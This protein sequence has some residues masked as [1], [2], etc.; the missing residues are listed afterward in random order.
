MRGVVTSDMSL[1]SIK[2]IVASVS[3]GKTGKAFMLGTEGEYI[4]FIDA[5]RDVDD[6]IQSDS[7]KNLAALGRTMLASTHG[8]ADLELNGKDCRVYY[9]TIA[10]SNWKIAVL[11]DNT[12]I[13]SS[14]RGSFLIMSIMPLLGLILVMISISFAAGHLRKVVGKVNRFSDIA[15]SGD[16]SRRIEV[17]EHDEFGIMET[18]LN[19]MMDNMAGMYARSLKLKEEA[20]NA[21]MAKSSFLSNMSH[22]MRTPLNAIIGMTAIG[23]LAKDIEKKDYAF[24]KVADASAHLLGVINDILD[25]SK[26]EANK[27]ELSPIE[28]DL[29]RMLQRVINV[30]NFRVDE[31]QQKLTVRIDK[32]IPRNLIGDDQRLSQVIANLLSNA[33]KFTPEGGSVHLDVRLFERTGDVCVLQFKVTDTGIGLSSDQQ[34]RLFMPFQQADNNTSRK[35]GGTGLGLT[36]SKRIVEMMGGEISIESV[37]GGGAIFSFTARLERGTN[38]PQSLLPSGIDWKNV[39]ILAV[40]DAPDIREYFSEIANI[41]GVSCDVAASGSEAKRLIDEKGSYDIYFVDWKMPGM[42][43]LELSAI[44]KAKDQEKSVII[45]I[46]SIEWGVIE[47]EAKAAGVKK[48]LPKPLFPSSVA[49]CISECLGIN[50]LRVSE[51]TQLDDMDGLEGFRVLIVEDVEINREIVL[52][53]LEPTRLEIDCAENG[54]EAVR[55]FSNAPDKYDI[56]FMDIQ[57]PEMDGYEATRRIRM[58]NQTVPIVAMTANVFREDVERCIASGMNDHVGKPLDVSEVIAKLRKYLTQK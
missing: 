45:M 35:Y 31:K 39:R 3:V 1:D 4:S 21:N 41:L 9:D 27:L 6:K 16:F 52:S 11:V 7:D 17:T 32:N 14:S 54:A 18:H 15:A 58:I 13:A 56:I 29:E 53:L 26:I 38:A 51:E 55:I 12:E 46:S 47:N 23:K 57:M 44:I 19:T 49:D 8:S 10:L 36:I 24:S 34:A 22:E 30:I 5:S 48:F 28:F 37:L 50:A 43:G 33:V 42:N 25:M 2:N 20:E 40:D